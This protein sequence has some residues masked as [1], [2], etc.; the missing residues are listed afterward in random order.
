[1][2]EYSPSPISTAT[3]TATPIFNPYPPQSI[4]MCCWLLI[5]LLILALCLAAYFW[6]KSK[7][8]SGR[9]KP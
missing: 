5:V 7:K 1:V 8:A 4:C 2:P 3:P 9:Y 6:W